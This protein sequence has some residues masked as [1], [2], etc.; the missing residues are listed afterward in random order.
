VNHAYPLVTAT[1]DNGL[2]VV[3]N[4]DPWVPGVAVNLWYGVGSADERPGTTGFA[5]LFEHLMFSG[6][7]QVAS[8]EYDT[9]L[10]GIGGN[11]NATTSFDRTSYFETVPS[12]G[13]ALALWLEAER[14]DSLLTR[15]DRV[16]LDTQREVVKEEK[17]QRYDN[18]PYGDAFDQL[19]SLVFPAGHPYAH[20]PIGS[21]EDLDRASLEDVHTFFHQYYAPDNVV[22]G[23]CGATS[24]SAALDLVE[25]YFSPIQSRTT[26]SPVA[27]A[28]LPPMREI[29]RRDVVAMVPQDVVYAAWLVPPIADP[30]T[31]PL[32]LALAVLTGSMTSRLH[33]KIVRTSVADSVDAFDLGLEHGNSLIVATAA[34]ADGVSPEAVEDAMMTVWDEFCSEGPTEQELTRVQRAENRQYLLDCASVRSRADHMCAAW[35]LFDDPE[36]L[37]RHL[38]V[39]GRI[40]TDDIA[41]TSADWLAAENRAVLTYRRSA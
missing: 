38:D 37:N 28:P 15:V 9:L 33:D 22:L 3:V 5:H 11:S 13:L 2:K 10:Q 40:T 20:L 17:R 31:D 7:E 1:L 23:I 32:N 19:M 14:L 27:V 18:V 4:S 30:V 26:A 8:G 41:Q 6:S 16:N 24:A 39:I 36:E 12:G 29:P 25:T 35:A 34:C 21:M